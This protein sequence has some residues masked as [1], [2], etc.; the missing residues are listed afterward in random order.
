MMNEREH[1]ETKGMS[2]SPD[3]CRSP[4]RTEPR[5]AG[6]PRRQPHRIQP[7]A[8]FAIRFPGPSPRRKLTTS[9]IK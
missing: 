5:L 9:G 2:R 4:G 6:I 8:V 7:E 3:D 1:S